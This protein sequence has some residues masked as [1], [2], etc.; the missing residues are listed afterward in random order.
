MAQDMEVSRETI[1]WV[2]QRNPTP[3]PAD[4][5]TALAAQAKEKARI[6]TGILSQDDP[7]LAGAVATVMPLLRR[8]T[9]PFKERMQAIREEQRTGQL[10]PKGV[11]QRLAALQEQL[12]QVQED[13]VFGPVERRLQAAEQKYESFLSP[14]TLTPKHRETATAVAAELQHLAPSHGLP[15][16]A[17]VL[18][19]AAK[20][21]EFGTVSAL[22]PFLKSKIETKG[23]EWYGSDEAFAMVRRMEDAAVS[24]QRPVGEARL[25]IVKDLQWKLSQL[26]QASVETHGDF[27]NHSYVRMTGG[28]GQVINDFARGQLRNDYRDSNHG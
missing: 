11:H 23:S 22:L 20:A 5:E 8:I 18:R 25:Q 16:V 15:R 14:P 6:V 9:E 3:L 27:E 7:D 4:L 17:E 10:T 13:Q 19:D 12:Q 24:W 26:R 28:D 1:A 21:N 2:S